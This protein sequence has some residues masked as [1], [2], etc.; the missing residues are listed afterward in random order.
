MSPRLESP[1]T[2]TKLI[3][4][5]LDY[6]WENLDTHERIYW[7]RLAQGASLAL[8]YEGRAPWQFS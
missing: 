3:P 7:S 4:G 6:I 8:Q 2:E 5:E 1:K